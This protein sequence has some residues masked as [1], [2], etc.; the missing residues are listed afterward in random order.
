MGADFMPN[1]AAP[2]PAPLVLGLQPAAL[3][4]HVAR[5]NWSLLDRVPG[6]R[7]GSIPVSI[8]ELEQI[9][10]EVKT[11]I[12]ST[13]EDPHPVKAMAGG[14]VANT[15]RGLSAGFG[16]S[17]GMVGAYGDDDQGQQFV[18]NMGCNGVDFSRMRKKE[19]PTGQCVCLVD[20]LG[21]R[22]MRP[23]LSSAVK[24][25]ADELT[26]E[27][28]NGAKWLVM[29]YGIFN[30]EVIKAAIGMAKQEGLLVSLDL[31]SFEMV[32]N[33]KAPLLE[34]LDSGN[35]DLCFA[36][37][38]EAAELLRGEQRAKPE[39]ALEFL[40]TRCKWAVVTLGPN[41]CIAKHGKE[42]V[43]VPAIGG[44]KATD[45][46]GAGDLFASGFLYGLVKG[47]SLEDCCK[48]GTC[49]GG[50]VIRSLGGEVTPENWQWMYKQMQIK[51]LPLPEIRN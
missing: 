23:C 35:I 24:L 42:I 32:R 11:H 22:T 17:T 13:H 16:I 37:E 4:D 39:A 6:E 43:R 2:A 46:T 48:V 29:R 5:V 31:A 44:A 21:N 47:L 26:H 50:S 38:D 36:N 3:I 18:S 9:L 49:S 33:F 1:G 7:G 15:I 34:L 45:A 41:G 14:S 25:Q 30:L 19:G 27:D 8:E 12:L 10:L 20:A 51:G 40:A 28:F